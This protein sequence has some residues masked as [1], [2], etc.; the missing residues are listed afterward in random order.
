[1]TSETSTP[2]RAARPYRL[3]LAI[4]AALLGAA[5]FAAL[6]WAWGFGYGGAGDPRA[7]WVLTPVFLA[8]WMAYA[9][10][11]GRLGIGGAIA[12]TILITAIHFTAIATT[13]F[14][15]KAQDNDGWMHI[16]DK[17]QAQADAWGAKHAGQFERAERTALEGGRKAGAI[18]AFASFALLL[19]FGPAFRRPAA[20]A[21]MLAVGA[22]LTLWGGYA[23]TQH[24]PEGMSPAEFALRLFLPWQ[25]LFGATIAVLFAGRAVAPPR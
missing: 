14:T 2:T 9:L 12:L 21:G 19:L 24:L 6:I 1:M 7:A 23:L 13:V 25:G 16:L 10:W 8:P 22:A 3:S 18:G 5:L 17:T 4:A 15:Y 11:T 20:L